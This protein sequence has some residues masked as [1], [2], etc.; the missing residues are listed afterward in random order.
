VVLRVQ[1][2]DGCIV[3]VLGLLFTVLLLHIN[4]SWFE[5][6]S[7]CLFSVLIAG[8][9][10]LLQAGRFYCGVSGVVVERERERGWVC[11][12]TPVL[13][14]RDRRALTVALNHQ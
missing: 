2:G 12:L 8:W 10:A 7:H 1:F 3:Y 4:S 5:V 14:S 11:K 9:Y 6:E 13:P